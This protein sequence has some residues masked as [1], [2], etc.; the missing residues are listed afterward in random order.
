MSFVSIET[1]VLSTEVDCWSDSESNTASSLTSRS[2]LRSESSI[3]TG[4]DTYSPS[5]SVSSSP[6][7]SF[8]S[9]PSSLYEIGFSG[10]EQGLC[11][12]SASITHCDTPDVHIDTKPNSLN[13]HRFEKIYKQQ[14][15]NKGFKKKLVCAQCPTCSATTSIGLPYCLPCSRQVFGVEFLHRVRSWNAAGE[16]GLYACRDFVKDEIIVPYIAEILTEKQAHSRYKTSDTVYACEFISPSKQRFLFD[17][18]SIRGI[19][20]LINHAPTKY[21]NAK[22]TYATVDELQHFDEIARWPLVARASKNIRKGDEILC[23]Y[24]NDAYNLNV[25]HSTT[26]GSKPPIVVDNKSLLNMYKVKDNMFHSD[27]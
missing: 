26:S 24:S 23:N 27:W 18:C 19:G 12:S 6:S 11:N 25:K 3:N 8:S 4:F 7:R 9:S 1:S 20:S 14:I 5:R 22:F 2:P 15:N 16:L 13:D 21:C 17:A 10:A